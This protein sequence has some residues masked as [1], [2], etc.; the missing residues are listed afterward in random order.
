VPL[1][2]SIP[3]IAFGTGSL[4]KG[5][6]SIDQVGQAIDAGFNHIG[7][8]CSTR[9]NYCLIHVGDYMLL[10]IIDTAQYYRNE[11]EVGR[12]IRES[13]LSRNQ[14]YITTKYSAGKNN[15]PWAQM[16]KSAEDYPLDIETS[17][18]NSLNFV[19]A[20]VIFAC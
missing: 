14:L 17:I 4:R 9:T 16:E 18:R 12:A 13:G 1:G 8:F 19:C 20:Y 2:H 15:A 6:E 7:A 3:G 5:Q 11:E 10:N